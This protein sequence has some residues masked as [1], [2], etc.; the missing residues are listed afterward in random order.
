MTAPIIGSHAFWL[1]CRTAAAARAPELSLTDVSNMAWSF[2]RV[3]MASDALLTALSERLA[4]LVAPHGASHVSRVDG[5][6]VGAAANLVNAYHSARAA[7]QPPH[8]AALAM[9]MS[10]T[11]RALFDGARDVAAAAD[12]AAAAAATSTASRSEENECSVAAVG[13]QDDVSPD[14]IAL[15]LIA[16]ARACDLLGSHAP[17][18]TSGAASDAPPAVVDASAAVSDAGSEGAA[19]LRL[20]LQQL[21]VAAG[22][23]V[24]VT[25]PEVLS[26]F[27]SDAIYRQ[28]VCNLAA[29]AHWSSLFN[30]VRAHA[31]AGAPDLPTSGLVAEDDLMMRAPEK[32]IL[33]E[34]SAALQQE[35]R[36]R[37]IPPAVEKA[38]LSEQAGGRRWR[39]E[40][41]S[42]PPATHKPA[43]VRAI[44][45]A[46]R[47]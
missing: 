6:F 37:H 21:L 11:A 16:S 8:A 39:A 25:P 35:L 17:L 3:H 41:S 24:L 34:A 9:L 5:D 40:R 44:I 20:S 12:A 36:R 23:R 15:L 47:V 31:P 43:G 29:V 28:L 32:G 10:V 7:T 22:M 4:V 45:N 42:A 2:A 46:W 26:T 30:G 1:G 38:A 33:S 14:D 18:S 13:A 27:S 19:A